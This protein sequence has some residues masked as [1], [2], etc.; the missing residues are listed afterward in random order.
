MS[1]SFRTTISN[2]LGYGFAV[3]L[4]ETTVNYPVRQETLLSYS[5]F[6]LNYDIGALVI[7]SYRS[8]DLMTFSI[9]TFSVTTLNI[10]TFIIVTFSITTLSI[11]ALSIIA[12]SI[13]ITKMR[14]SLMTLSTMAEHCYS[15][16]LY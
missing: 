8:E 1:G 16:A 3:W 4:N 9:A 14:Q 6:S 12:F 7:I 2:N 15:Q 11:T 5:N 13:T 10:M